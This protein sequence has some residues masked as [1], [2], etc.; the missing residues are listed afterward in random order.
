[1]AAQPRAGRC[2]LAQRPQLAL[3]RLR[4]SHPKTS[5]TGKKQESLPREQS[6]PRALPAGTHGGSLR[7]PTGSVSSPAVRPSAG[8]GLAPHTML[9]VIQPVISP[10]HAM[11]GGKGFQSQPSHISVRSHSP[12]QGR[13]G[14]CHAFDIGTGG[15]GLWLPWGERDRGAVAPYSHGIATV[16]PCDRDAAGLRAMQ[17]LL[18]Q[19][20]PAALCRGLGMATCRA[21]G[22]EGAGVVTPREGVATGTCG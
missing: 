1:M 12:S 13:A 6:S 18:P 9:G 8:H 15:A 14:P 20:C 10:G 19:L 11:Q 2:V 3:A 22:W 16:P 4:W 21:W 7:I 17:L 5:D